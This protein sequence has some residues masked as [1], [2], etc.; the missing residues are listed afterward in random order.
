[1]ATIKEALTPI[2]GTYDIKTYTVTKSENVPIVIDTEN[3]QIITSATKTETYNYA[4]P[5]IEYIAGAVLLIVIL[6]SFFKA[7]GGLL[8]RL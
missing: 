8:K 4:V 6:L 7:I 3:G 5:D 1:M 2:L